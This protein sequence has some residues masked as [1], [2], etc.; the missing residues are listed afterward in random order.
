M[1][2]TYIFSCTLFV[3]CVPHPFS[4]ADPV[5]TSLRRSTSTNQ[6][7]LIC[8]STTSPATTVRWTKD[9]TEIVMD[10]RPYQH[11][12]VVTSRRSSTYQNILTST[13]TPA[14]TLGA[15]TCTVSNRFGSSSRSVT[16]RGQLVSL[17]IFPPFVNLVTPS[18]YAP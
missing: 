15:Y 14:S 11:S 13:G 9:G 7:T 3:Q 5:V 16:I 12:Q 4:P 10:G 8:T 17:G 2:N 6:F 1:P 18:D